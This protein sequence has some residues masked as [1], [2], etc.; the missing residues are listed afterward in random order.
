MKK[1][2]IFFY[3]FMTATDRAIPRVERLE[4]MTWRIVERKTKLT[5]AIPPPMP[6]LFLSAIDGI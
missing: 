5:T 6:H 1:G 3:V 2:A 4:K